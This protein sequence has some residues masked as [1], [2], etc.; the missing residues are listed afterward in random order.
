LPYLITLVLA[1]CLGVSVAN[2]TTVV[3][4]IRDAG[5]TAVPTGT[6]VHFILSQEA[7]AGGV[8]YLG[9]PTTV[10]CSTT[11]GAIDA[12]CIVQGNETLSPAGTY[13]RVRIVTSTGAQLLPERRYT[14]SGAT[15]DIGAN[16]PQ[17]ADVLAATS[18]NQ[19]QEESAN[20]IRQNILNFIGTGV[21]CVNNNAFLRTDCTFTGG[22]GSS[23]FND[24]T[25]GTNTTATM[26]VGTGGILTFSGTATLNARSINGTIFSNA[27]S[28]GK[29]PIGQG[30]GTAAWADPLVQGLTAHDVAGSTT[31]PVAVGGYASAAAPADVSADTDIVRGWFTRA[32]AQATVL[33]AAGALIGGDAANGLDVDVTRLPALPAGTNNIGDVDVLTLPS[34]TIGTFPD[35]EPFNVAQMNGVA[36]SMGA[37]ATG[38]GVQRVV[39]ANNEAL[40]PGTNNIGDVDVLTLPALPTGTN[41][42]GDVDVLTLPSVTIG[43][44]P[45]NEPFNLAQLNAVALASPVDADTGAGTENLVKISLRKAASGGSLEYGTSSDPFNVVFPSAQ[46]VTQS[47]SWTVT[48]NAGTNLNTSSLA[49]ESSLAKLTLTQGSTTSG[50]S[51]PLLQ[52]AVTTSVPSYTTAQTS[53]LSLDTSGG[54]RVACITG[55]GGSGGTAATDNTAFTGGSTQ[56]TPIGAIFDAT[57]PAITDG[58][59]GAPRM[60]SIRIL[61]VD[62]QSGC[63]GSSFADNSAFTFGTTTIANMGAVVDDTATNTVAENSAGAPRMNTNRILYSMNTNSTGTEVGT[64]GSPLRMDPTGTTTQPVSISQTSSINDV[65]VLT[66]PANM[67]VNIN[68]VAGSAVG[69]AASGVQK[70]GVVGNAGATL[71]ATVAPGTAPT[72]AIATLGQ[73]KDTAPAPTDAQTVAVQ[74]DQSGNQRIAPGMA[75]KTLSAWN[76]GTSVNATQNIF[77]NSGSGAVLVHLVQTTTLTAGAITFEVS[78]D[79]TNWVTLPADAVLDSA[80]TTFAQIS[81]PYTVQASTNKPFLLMG[82]GWQGLRIKLSTAITGTGSVTPNYA[83]LSNEPAKTMIAL[84]PTAANFNATL[85]AGTSNIGD[86]DVLSFPDNEPINVAQMNGVAVTMNNGVVGTGVQRVT[87]AS[88]STGQVAIASMPNEGQQT[89]A[90]SISVTPDTDNDAIGATAAAVPGEAIMTG[91]TDGTNLIAHFIDPC[92]REAKTYVAINQTAGTQLATGV[93]SERIYICSVNVVTATAQNIALVSGTGTVCATS[94]AGL[95]GFGGATAATGCNFAANS[96]ISYG[97]GSS[98]LGRTDTDADNLCLFQSGAGQVSGGISYV[99][100]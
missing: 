30:D 7:T 89:A 66:V 40:P 43:T 18:Y 1:L 84:S 98:A 19:I 94:T 47:G 56:V 46:A 29:I 31:N 93:A 86:V 13:Y 53:P 21:T 14:I 71:D 51:G 20:L 36:V 64:S 23:A 25:S 58:N 61:L 55:C 33:T 74:L 6:K 81:L 82:K 3:G 60:S 67:S 39:L 96:G 41:N 16:S 24:I 95:E 57:P 15:W 32:G 26:T 27:E 28:L 38:T 70:V 68:Q 83:L 37:G 4:T 88:D 59:V 54:L 17:P 87:L 11:S 49:L 76:S 99:S 72:N 12:L 90:N 34:V 42:I 44:F 100:R 78:Y 77:T 9:P 79:N 5:G 52:A 50:Q 97:N 62:C 85:G 91:G 69:T 65:D 35:N 2:A 92:Q 75:V 22:G 63:A 45:D 48:A 73:Y 10:I 8:L 80:S